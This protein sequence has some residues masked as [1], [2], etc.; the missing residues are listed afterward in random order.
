MGYLL[1]IAYKKLGTK[2][3]LKAGIGI[4]SNYLA[5]KIEEKY[6]QREN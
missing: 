2:L 4:L 5:K 3:S 1:R 6:I